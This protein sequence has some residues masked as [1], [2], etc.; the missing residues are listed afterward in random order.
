MS[1]VDEALVELAPGATIDEALPTGVR[2]TQRMPPR[3]AIVLAAEDDLR[4]LERDPRVRRVFRAE[5]ADEDLAR[6]DDQERLFAAAWNQRRE[7]S[8]HRVGEGLAWDA[9]GLDPP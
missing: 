8:K 2:V 1:D 3:L 7:G 6:L 9:P 5:V 4:A